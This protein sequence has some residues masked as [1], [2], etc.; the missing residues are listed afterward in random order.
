MHPII[1]TR[2]PRSAGSD[3][4]RP[5]SVPAPA[6][7]APELHSEWRIVTSSHQ[8]LL[9]VGPTTATALVV[10]ALEPHL[11]QPVCRCDPRIDSIL[12]EPDEGA[13]VISAVDRLDEAQQRRM[14][15]WL[16]GANAPVQVVCTTSE[17]LFVLVLA[18]GFLADLY[19]RLN[20][21]LLDLTPRS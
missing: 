9:I 12:P 10:A 1:S 7:L 21:V 6:F 5:P 4:H 3:S 13:L 19:Y 18:G 17:P 14:M 20:V 15:Q 8:N 16:N 11:R 2:L